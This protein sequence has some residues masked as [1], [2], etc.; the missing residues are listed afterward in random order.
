[1]VPPDVLIAFD[2]TLELYRAVT[3]RNAGPTA[4]VEAL[5]AE[6]MSS[7][8]TLPDDYNPKFRREATKHRTGQIW[9]HVAP[10]VTAQ[11]AIEGL[12]TGLGPVSELASP[13]LVGRTNI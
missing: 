2:D 6:V 4:F 12:G 8:V 9:K 7:G 1:M 5:G 3:G 13:A 10:G 11:C